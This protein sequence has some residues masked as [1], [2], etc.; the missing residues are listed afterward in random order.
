MPKLSPSF[1]TS[2][3]TAKG[4]CSLLLLLLPPLQ[5]LRSDLNKVASVE[6]SWAAGSEK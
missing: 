4:L 2:E 5:A 6:E 3:L 1:A